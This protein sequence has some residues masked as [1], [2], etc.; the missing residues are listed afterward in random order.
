[1]LESENLNGPKKKSIIKKM[2]MEEGA[3]TSNI[4]PTKKVSASKKIM[5]KYF[6]VFFIVLI[7]V[8]AL[9]SFYFY[10]KSIST[11]DQTSQK[12]TNALVQKVG[13]LVILPEGEVPTI[14]TVSDPD[15][16][17][18]QAF[19]VDAK[20][21]YKVLIYSKDQKAILYDP[22]SK[23][24]VNIAPINIDANKTKKDPVVTTDDTK[25]KK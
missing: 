8:L 6:G 15:A 20:K 22:V 18:G 10:K 23:R 7:I 13:K 14:A 12:E 4:S 25:S 2:V 19:F 24:V 9:T 11:A 5:K 3:I 16:L 17:K 21:G 1:M